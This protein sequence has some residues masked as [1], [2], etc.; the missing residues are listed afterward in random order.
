MK[1]NEIKPFTPVLMKYSSCDIWRPRFFY[2]K[3]P[4]GY[5][6]INGTVYDECVVYEGNE[7]LL[8]T[9]ERK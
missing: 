1:Q 8:Y 7:Y 6:D 2:M 4:H 9:G 3:T 5:A